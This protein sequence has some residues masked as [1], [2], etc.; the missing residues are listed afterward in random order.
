MDELCCPYAQK[1]QRK[2]L[3]QTAEQS[4]VIQRGIL[5]LL[6]LHAGTRP[7]TQNNSI[8]FCLALPYKLYILSKQRVKI[9]LHYIPLYYE[10]LFNDQQIT[11]YRRSLIT[12]SLT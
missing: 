5:S 2:E 4:Q 3:G 10:P 12:L 7:G 8:Y 11:F 9:I 6:K 1:L